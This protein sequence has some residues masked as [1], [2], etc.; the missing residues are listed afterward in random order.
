MMNMFP[1][2]PKRLIDKLIGSFVSVKSV[3]TRASEAVKNDAD[4]ETN[5]PK[6]HIAYAHGEI[7]AA[8]EK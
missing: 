2:P 3:G 6:C 1:Y 5:D 7:V 8:A 4:Q